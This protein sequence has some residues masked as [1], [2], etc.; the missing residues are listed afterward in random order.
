MEDGIGYATSTDVAA[1]VSADRPYGYSYSSGLHG[2]AVDI[3]NPYS[4]TADIPAE[5][6][7]EL[8]A[9]YRAEIAA[10]Q[11]ELDAHRVNLPGSAIGGSAR[12]A[13]LQAQIDTLQARI[14]E[15]QRQRRRDER[16]RRSRNPGDMGVDSD[17]G[18]LNALVRSSSSPETNA[19]SGTGSVD[20]STAMVQGMLRY[21]LALPN[22]SSGVHVSGSRRGQ[23]SEGGRTT[24]RNPRDPE[25]GVEDAAPAY[26]Q[27]ARDREVVVDA[28]EPESPPE[29][30]AKEG[31]VGM[32]A[33]QG[34]PGSSA[35]GARG[36]ARG[37]GTG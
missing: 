22:T 14:A 33:D 18:A 36:G 26:V 8:E 7:D 20:P 30:T 16:L 21:V 19:G 5:W 32:R 27:E 37:S 28:A 11:A 17:W 12:E 10:A 35:G 31:E 3:N 1:G 34:R 13:A 29:Y 23:R 25:G 15:R 24:Y 6:I 2:H 9:G 4:S